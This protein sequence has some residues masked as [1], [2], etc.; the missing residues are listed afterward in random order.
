MTTFCGHFF[1][2]IVVKTFPFLQHPLSK[3]GVFWL[4]GSISLTGTLFFYFFLPET[5]GHTL[6]EIE[7]YFSGRTETLGKHKKKTAN[8]KN[9]PIVLAPKKGQALPS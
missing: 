6:Q 1:V 2:F 4:Y 9:R 3:H 8:P 5:K 7:D